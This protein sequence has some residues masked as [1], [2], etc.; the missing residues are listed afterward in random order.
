RYDDAEQLV[1]DFTRVL[2]GEKPIGFEEPAGGISGNPKNREKKSRLQSSIQPRVAPSSPRRSG[3]SSPVVPV[4]VGKTSGD[5]GR[6]VKEQAGIEPLTNSENGGSAMSDTNTGKVKSRRIKSTRT[7]T[8]TSV[9]SG[10][11][12]PPGLERPKVKMKITPGMVFAFLFFVLCVF[13][14]VWSLS[15]YMKYNYKTPKEALRG[16]LEAIP[17]DERDAYE[18]VAIFFDGKYDDSKAKE[19]MELADSFLENYPKSL[20]SRDPAKRITPQEYAELYRI[21]LGISAF[22]QNIHPMAKKYIG[23]VLT[24]R[25][26]IARPRYVRVL[27]K[28]LIEQEDEKI[29]LT[30]AKYYFNKKK[31]EV[32][33][34]LEN[35]ADTVVQNYRR[36]L[37]ELQS[38]HQSNQRRFEQEKDEVLKGLLR[39]L[40]VLDF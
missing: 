22:A 33:R 14:F 5:R 38:I 34:K 27:R 1:L 6:K 13:L 28:K 32:W 15:T 30:E 29:A 25:N 16:Y 23:A 2:R 37:N 11:Y 18:N 26:E 7:A 4:S 20:F 24:F 35:Y 12:Q 3:R 19:V 40:S 8:Q 31:E 9:G 39:I 21:P 36:Q 17:K 10:V